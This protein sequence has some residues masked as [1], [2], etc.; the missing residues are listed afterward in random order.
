MTISILV[1]INNVG[2]LTKDETCVLIVRHDVLTCVA[3]TSAFK[4][5]HC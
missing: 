4:F 1:I 2:N 3:V 5:I